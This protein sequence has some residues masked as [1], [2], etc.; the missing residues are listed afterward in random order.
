MDKKNKQAIDEYCKLQSNQESD[1]LK[2]I[3]DFTIQTEPGHAMISGPLVA[4]FLQSV[5]RISQSKNILEIGMYTGYS[6]VAMA[7][8]LPKDGVIHTCEIMERH[9]ETAR[10]FFDQH[11]HPAQLII[12][13]GDA[14]SIID[15]FKIN[16]FDM[17]F[18]DADKLNYIKYYKKAMTLVRNGGIIILDNMLW[19]GDVL[20]PSSDESKTL[21]SLNKIITKDFRN[22]N[23]LLPIRDGL[24][25]CLK[26][27]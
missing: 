2:N 24:M 3:R 12:H 8:A 1:L 20:S 26:N 22:T 14:L 27:E 21:S 23:T 9:I 4:N 16:T 7:E 11:Q 13:H 15:E 17:I 5:I 19:G 25:L 6:A 10:G 18:I